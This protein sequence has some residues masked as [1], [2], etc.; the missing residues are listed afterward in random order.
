MT[1]SEIN[2]M[3]KFK[4]GELEVEAGA[5]L[6]MEGSSSPQLYTALTGMGLRY[7]TLE[8]GNRQV[9]NFVLPG[10]FI[11]LQAG[12]MQQ[13]KHSVEATTQ[14]RLCVF[15]RKHLW[16][17]F[18]DHPDRAFDLTW[19]A[20]V[21]EHYLGE[22][23]AVIGRME[24]VERV[25]RAFVKLFDQAAALGLT[26]E[27]RMRLPYRQQDIADAIGLSLVHTN[28]MVKRLRLDGLADWHDGVLDILDYDGLCKVAH[29]PPTRGPETRPLM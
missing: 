20:A 12:V 3:A 19:V 1:E 8:N 18:R 26:K 22:T 13:M 25:A 24:A 10:D 23:L 29:V 14:M 28:K 5:T 27:A 2:F 17:L 15:D 7:K 9:I 16:T 21:E 6:M 11:G 4:V